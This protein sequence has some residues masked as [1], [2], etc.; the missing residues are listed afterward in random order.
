MESA[1]DIGL[2]IF[3]GL[4]FLSIIGVFVFAA[5]E[6]FSDIKGA[7]GAIMGII[8]L[9]VVFLISYFLSTADQGAFY[10][11]MNVSAFLSKTIGAGLI[12]TYFIFGGAIISIFYSAVNN[13]FR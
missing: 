12:A 7:K 9:A 5:I 2:Y 10:D 8:I 3:Y 13:W 4:L 6:T 1:I 11:K